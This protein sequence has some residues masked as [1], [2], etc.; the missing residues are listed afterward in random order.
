MI[1]FKNRR[2]QHD[3]RLSHGGNVLTVVAT[4]FQDRLTVRLPQFTR[5]FLDSSHDDFACLGDSCVERPMCD[6][7]GDQE[8]WLC[9]SQ[10]GVLIACATGY[11]L[12]V[13]SV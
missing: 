4:T 6:Q 7:L 2:V 8:G 9:S 12:A 1:V 11:L 10:G 3:L 13:K 5:Q